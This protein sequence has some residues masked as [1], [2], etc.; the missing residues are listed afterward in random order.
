MSM[1]KQLSVFLE[2]RPGTLAKVLRALAA[3]GVNLLGI[4]IVDGVDHA[5]VRMVVDRV[6]EALHVLGEAG[7]LAVESDIVGIPV[8]NSPG[9]LAKAAA[10]LSKAKINIEYAYGSSGNGSEGAYLF[11]QT[12]DGKRAI[13]QSYPRKER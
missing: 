7:V 2:N 3:K 10:S 4:S 6:R 12:T 1:H 5:V 11:V 13:R 8:S 9:A